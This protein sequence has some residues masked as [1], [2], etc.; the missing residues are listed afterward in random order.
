MQGGGGEGGKEG[1]GCRDRNEMI[2]KSAKEKRKQVRDLTRIW[3]C[4]RARV[5]VFMRECVY[6]HIYVYMCV[7]VRMN[8]CMYMCV[9]A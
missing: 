3:S 1:E 9:Y 7:S 4:T 2:F 5:C 6:M 8:M